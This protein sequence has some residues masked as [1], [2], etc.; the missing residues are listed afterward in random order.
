VAA[1]GDVLGDR[2]VWPYIDA[3]GG[4]ALFV[5]VKQ[6]FT[7][8]DVAFVNL[9]GPISTKGYPIYP[10][11]PVF[12]AHPDLMNG[13]L[14]A[15]ID[16]VSLANNHMLDYTSA[17]LLDCIARLDAAGVQHAG[18]GANLDA[19]FKPAF[20]ETR[21]GTVGL[22]AYCDINDNLYAA[23]AT[24]PGIAPFAGSSVIVAQVQAAAALCDFLIVSFH[25]GVETDYTVNAAERALAHKVVDAGADIILAQHPHVMQGL[26][27][28]KD[29]L[30][31]YSLGN[32]VFDHYRYDWGESFILQ[33]IVPQE[34][35]PRG[36][37]IPVY[38][39]GTGVPSVVTGATASAI[40]N[41]LTSLSASL[42][43]KLTRWGDRAFFGY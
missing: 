18:A 38:L 4:E 30:I 23:T 31:A 43:L 14:S 32:F 17:A 19:A 20:W 8:A 26:E 25:W 22:L 39:A 15:G 2:R 40:L 29:K 10:T 34:G 9:E 24:K 36:E 7:P 11:G 37:I 28:Y 33:V 16:V 27:I 35:P 6:Y 13:L 1:G 5:H 3:Y 42:G 41:R 12:R 21:A